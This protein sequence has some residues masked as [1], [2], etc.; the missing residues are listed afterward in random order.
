M[1]PHHDEIGER[2]VNVLV[3]ILDCHRHRDPDRHA[4]NVNI[5][6]ES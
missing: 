5:R 6:C 2:G 3:R 1:D 4:H